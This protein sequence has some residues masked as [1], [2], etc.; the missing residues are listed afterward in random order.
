[1]NY[2]YNKKNSLIFEIVLKEFF[3]KKDVAI[4]LENLL[5]EPMRNLINHPA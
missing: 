4:K 3:D 1:M 2:A 5:F